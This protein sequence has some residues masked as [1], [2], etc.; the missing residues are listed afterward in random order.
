M[1]K[2]IYALSGDPVTKGHLDI[3]DRA[4]KIFD[5]LI[6][7]IG[8][9]EKKINSYIFDINER[10]NI[11]M[12][13]TKKLRE[14]RNIKIKIFKSSLAD[15]ALLNDVNVIVRG[16]RNAK[17]FQEE[18]NLASVN[19]D[20]NS[21]LETCFIMSDGSISYVSSSMTKE[22][23]ELN[24]SATK[25]LPKVSIAELQKKLN[26]QKFIG[27]TGLMGSGKSFISESLA[28]YSEKEK[29]KIY[30]LDLDYLCHEVYDEENEDFEI[31]R[32]KIKS[33]FGT[34]DRAVISKVVFK[35]EEKLDKLNE[36]F[37]PII[38]YQIRKKSKGLK[39]IILINGATLVKMGL[40]D[41]CNNN[42]IMINTKD[43]KRFERCKEGRGIDKEIVEKRDSIM[44]SLSEQR[45]I[46]SRKIQE[47]D[48]GT[49][50]EVDNSSMKLNISKLY[51]E[52]IKKI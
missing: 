29:E 27:I 26:N 15:F 21:E 14:N 32:K 33:I 42:V 51:E 34:L 1:K 24:H 9:N 17:D 3:I 8:E 16:L 2:A 40:L 22:V 28:K 25:Y 4:S 44:L 30:N 50:I 43:E 36:I 45:G 13:A 46:I 49:L 48:Y 37:K 20:I 19:K 38:E 12:K 39:G 35:D 11:I 41:L 47:D 31:Q 18:Q 23:V 5:E 7:A 10:Y 52:I 6:I